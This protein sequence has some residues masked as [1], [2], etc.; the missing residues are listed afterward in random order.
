MWCSGSA[1]W[2]RE[3]G[4]KG[5]TSLFSPLARP[6]HRRCVGLLF[7]DPDRRAHRGGGGAALWRRRLGG[8]GVRAQGVQGVVVGAA[9]AA[10]HRRGQ[11][12]SLMVWA[13]GAGA[14]IT[15]RGGRGA[16]HAA[17]VPWTFPTPW[18]QTQMP[19]IQNIYRLQLYVTDNTNFVRCFIYLFL[20]Q[21][22]PT[23]DIGRWCF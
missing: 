3:W 19:L 9:G 13:E 23:T 1:H 8:A 11:R 20:H 4:I 7:F 21:R 17:V 16:A 18:Q 6:L 5:R 15:E 22:Y 14:E 10:V 2:N 12:S